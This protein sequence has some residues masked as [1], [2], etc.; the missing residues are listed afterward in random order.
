MA[1]ESIDGLSPR[2]LHAKA[3]AGEYELIDRQLSPLG[4]RAMK[5]L[6]LAPASTVVDVGCGT[7]QTILQLADWVGDE[8]WIYGVDISEELLTVANQCTSH[9]KCVQLINTDAQALE[10]P[11]YSADAIFSRFGVMSF[12]D[13]IVAFSNFH[14]LLKPNGRI[15]FCCWRAFCDNELDR[16][17]L[18]AAGF[19][20]P[21]DETPFSFSDAEY[22]RNV[23]ASAGF[24][25]IEIAAYDEAVTSGDVDAMTR[26]LLSVGPLGKIARE[27]P[28]VKSAAE[29]KLRE[30]LVS[31]GDGTSVALVASVCIVSAV[32]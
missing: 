4:L 25:D 8:G 26:V 20:S 31:L 2:Q 9:L 12:N 3:W 17:P 28:T 5:E 1:E 22:V 27:N 30:G 14:R 13:P 7:G 29:P 32:A 10:L 21:L 16:F 11:S 18:L 6:H 24:K 19:R 15:A 23:L